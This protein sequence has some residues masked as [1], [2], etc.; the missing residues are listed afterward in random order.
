MTGIATAVMTLAEARDLTDEV[1]EDAA[2]LWTKLLRLYEGG[3]HIALGYGSW[4]EFY[5]E[6]FGQTARTGYRLLEAARVAEVL[7]DTHVTDP[8]SQNVALTLAPGLREDGPDAVRETWQKVRER[9]GS[10][11]TAKQTA[12]VVHEKG[13]GKRMTRP[14]T[15]RKPTDGPIPSWQIR[16]EYLVQALIAA[17][18]AGDDDRVELAREALRW[19]PDVATDLE[20]LAGGRA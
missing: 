11:P 1:K 7:S 9:H 4:G 2:R 19:I 15:I 5:A 16:L 20:R 18:N 3:A 13:K 17:A 8:P 6:E 14:A 10:T 12:S